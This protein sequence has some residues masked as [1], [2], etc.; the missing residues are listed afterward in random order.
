MGEPVIVGRIGRPHGIRGDVTI[1]VRTD[2]PERRFAP[3]AVLGRQRPG[4]PAGSA[5]AAVPT[6]GSDPGA[7][8]GPAGSADLSAASVLRVASSRW[9][10]GRLLVRFDGVADRGAAEAL[11]GTLLTIDSDESGPPVGDDDE[12]ETDDLWWDRDLVGLRAQ[13]S[14][15]AALGEVVDVIHSPAGEILAISRSGGGEYLIPF[16]REI[17]PTV[18]PAA[19]RIVV[20]P[21][22]GLLDL[23]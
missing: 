8:T 22:P 15:G 21:P 17:V 6:A 13:T 5:A 3:G 19:G 2:L 23:D 11:R 18:D 4:G 20:D 7:R 1:D 16:V 10:S 9:H 12:D 14:A